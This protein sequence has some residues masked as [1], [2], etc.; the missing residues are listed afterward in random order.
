MYTCWD[1]TT[2]TAATTTATEELQ[3]PRPFSFT[4]KSA[5]WT[6]AKGGTT[7]SLTN[8]S[9]GTYQG[10]GLERNKNRSSR[11]SSIVVV[12]VA[13]AAAVVVV[14]VVARAAE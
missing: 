11:V 5:A 6:T 2:T 9:V 7:H 13:A 8:S 14:V 12:V 10:S 1:T 4:T 3:I